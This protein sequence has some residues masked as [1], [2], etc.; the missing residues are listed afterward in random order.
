[1]GSLQKLRSILRRL[2]TVVVAYS[3]G[4]DSAFLLKIASDTLGKNVL[5]VT[6]VS[7][8]YPDSELAEARK[9]AKAVG[10]RHVVIKTNEIADNR[11]SRNSPDRCY[12]CKKEL[13]VKLRSLARTYRL[14]YVVDASNVSDFRDYRPGRKAQV[15]CGIRSPLQEAGFTKSAIRKVSKAWGLAT[16]DKPAQA[17]LASRIPYGVRIEKGILANIAQAE[18]FLKAQG[19]LHVRVRHYGSLCRIEVPENDI[20]RLV[21]KRALILKKVKTLGYTYITVD[22]EG[23][24]TG[25]MNEVL[26]PTHYRAKFNA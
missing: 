19:F 4:V 6:A 16:W 15:E 13:F 23:Y 26:A 12:F 21:R 25:S 3:G 5:A 8:T 17:C 22:L 9:F 10:C 2:G 18:S 20:A 7:P 14:R 1:M 11:F 24:R